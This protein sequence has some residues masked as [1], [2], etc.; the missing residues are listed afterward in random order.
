MHELAVLFAAFA[1]HGGLEICGGGRWWLLVVGGFF[2][3]SAAMRLCLADVLVLFSDFV[4][5]LVCP[6]RLRSSNRG[7]GSAEGGV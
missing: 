6:R 3:R 7:C 4:L 2:C 1:A 5:I